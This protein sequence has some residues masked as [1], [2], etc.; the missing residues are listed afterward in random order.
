MAGEAWQGQSDWE[1][2]LEGGQSTV[3]GEEEKTGGTDAQ[4]ETVVVTDVG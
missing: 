4:E 3:I 1:G 2:C